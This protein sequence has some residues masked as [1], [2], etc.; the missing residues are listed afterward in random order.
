MSSSNLYPQASVFSDGTSNDA[1]APP[2]SRASLSRPRG[3]ADYSLNG[4]L[5]SRGFNWHNF[6]PGNIG[7]ASRIAYRTD[8][9]HG[10]LA[11]ACDSIYI[12]NVVMNASRLEKRFHLDADTVMVRRIILHHLRLS[13]R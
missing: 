5:L 9:V 7:T 6:S 12:F 2:Q 10:W 3:R 1:Q 4:L 8:V 11:Q 13:P